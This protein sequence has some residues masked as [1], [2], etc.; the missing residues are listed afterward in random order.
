MAE[1][2][3]NSDGMGRTRTSDGPDR[4]GPVQTAQRNQQLEH[5]A[6]G[7][8]Q[9]DIRRLAVYAAAMP[10]R[11][12]NVLPRPGPAGGA[13][14]CGGTVGMVRKII[15]KGEEEKCRGKQRLD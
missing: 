10:V 4:I 11:S 7:V 3:P 5:T 9:S 15:A 14:G 6:R 1:L 2:V 12:V 13:C 8:C